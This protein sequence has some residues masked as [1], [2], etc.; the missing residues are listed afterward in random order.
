MADTSVDIT[1][2]NRVVDESLSQGMVEEAI[3]IICL[4]DNRL[5]YTIVDAE[6]R[7]AVALLDYHSATLSEVTS[8]PAGLL[9]RVKQG[10]ELLNKVVFAKVVVPVYANTHS[11]I[12]SPLFSR[13]RL[14]ET[15]E[16]TNTVAGEP[17]FLNDSIHSAN[18]QFIYACDE[19]LMEELHYSFR[20]PLVFHANSAFIESELRLNK[21]ESEKMVSVNLRPGHL[22]IVVTS[23]NNL[24]FFNTFNVNT[25]EDFMYYLL[26][27]MEQL[28]LNPDQTRVR[29]Y[30]DIE[31]SGAVWLLA[32]KYIRNVE[33][34]DRPGLIAYSYGFEKFPAHQYYALF[35]QYL[36]VS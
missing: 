16:L 27:T 19:D 26:F 23:A 35:C 29:C 20:E 30:G 4:D 15:L 11:L 14:R 33:L 2:K 8:T 5:T 22:D 25:A 32:R 3:L 9:R 7:K 36:C 6:R 28:E 34:G 10:D 18:A 24:V 13:D 21:H 17:C 12:P 1:P 31:K